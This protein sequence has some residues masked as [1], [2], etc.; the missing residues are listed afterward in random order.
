[1]ARRLQRPDGLIFD[2]DGT[3]VDTVAARIE[4]WLEAFEGA[5]I[6]A[7]RDQIGPMIGMDGKRLAREVANAV[8]RRLSDDEVETIDRASGEAFDRLNRSPRPLPGVPDAIAAIEAVGLR[9]VI[10]TSSRREQVAASVAAL[11]LAREPEIVDGSQ[12]KHAKPAPDLLLL[13]AERLGAA[14]ARC[15]AAGDSTWDMR[16]SAA[17][18]MTGIGVTAGSAVS[19]EALLEAGAAVVVATLAELASLLRDTAA[20]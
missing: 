4:S 6:A 11:G 17:A 5:G 8:G 7:D 15:W 16:A 19:R 3:L 9:W 18:G 20:G 2:L 12:V 13:A 10:A 14:P 1:L